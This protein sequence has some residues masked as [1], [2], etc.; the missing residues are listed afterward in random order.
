MLDIKTLLSLP[1]GKTLEFK[2][3]L[4][5]VKPIIKTL[6]AFANTAG[7]TIIIGKEQNGTIC[8]IEDVY[9]MEEKLANATADSIYPP[10][11]PEI[12]I[13]SVEGKTL[14]IVRVA[15]WWGPFY[16]KS[17]GP[18]EGVYVRLGSTNRVAGSE[19]LEELKRSK[20]KVSFDQLPCHDIDIQGLDLQ[21]IERAF[22]NTGR[23]IDHHKLTSLGILVPYSG[24]LVCSNGGIILFGQ[25]HIRHR[26]FPNSVVRCARFAGEEK[27]DFIDHLD[28]EGTIVDAMHEVPKFV[29]RHT[30][31]AT[32]IEDIQREDIPEYSPIAFREVL[33]NALVHADYSIRGMNLRIA[34]FSD[35]LEV[36][37]PGMLPFGYTF[38]DF[39]AGVSHIRNKVIARVF[40][41]LHLMEEWGT[42]YKRV[43]EAC[44]KSGY[45]LPVWEELGTSIH[46]VFRS[47]PLAEIA[48]KEHLPQKEGLTVRQEAIL[49][50]FHQKDQMTAKEVFSHLGQKI[51]ERT[52]RV[53]LLHLQK[54]GFLTKVGKGPNSLW[55]LS[56]RTNT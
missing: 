16:L 39:F 24:K 37:S 1:E 45:N 56:P 29:R 42:G 12:E 32:K 9:G 8:G 41:E 23:K 27:V 4:S 13:A 34:I 35:R 50:L 55:K 33:T 31:M 19:L 11:L 44:R 2:R 47:Q 14:L 25:D 38:E 52:V 53:D 54:S 48:L 36:E 20:S 15:H 26:F 46:V 21:R 30:R 28:I 51:S 49:E 17:Q 7:G 3:D 5:S 10:F 6:I 18:V 40:R 43:V 22:A